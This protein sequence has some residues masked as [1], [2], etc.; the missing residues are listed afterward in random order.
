MNPDITSLSLEQKMEYLLTGKLPR[1]HGKPPPKT[2]AERQKSHRDRQREE[3]RVV[4]PSQKTRALLVQSLNY[5]LRLIDDP[6]TSNA[7][8]VAL[9]KAAQR[10][11][12]EI[13]KRYDFG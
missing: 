11:I 4:N 10:T 6:K 7:D 13:S 1:R 8:M 2:S 3:R 9:R 12:S 5:Y